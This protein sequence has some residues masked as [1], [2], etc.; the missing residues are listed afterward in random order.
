[1]NMTDFTQTLPVG[2]QIGTVSQCEEVKT[3]VTSFQKDNPE[4]RVNKVMTQGKID[5]SKAKLRTV[6]SGT[7]CTLNSSELEALYVL[8]TE[9]H[10]VFSLEENER[11]ETDLVQLTI[12]TGN[13][14]L[15]R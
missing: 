14:S 1:M 12:D 3:S 7:Y 13:A 15:L 11:G 2:T 8:L 5:D 9:H 10:E 4:V 6:M